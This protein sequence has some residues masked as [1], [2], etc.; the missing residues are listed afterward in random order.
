VTNRD[1]FRVYP[2]D[3]PY[4]IVALALFL[5]A[6]TIY[7]F[8]DTQCPPPP[9]NIPPTCK[10]I[11]VNPG[12]EGSLIGPGNILDAAEWARRMELFNTVQYWREKLKTAPAGTP[13][14]PPAPSPPAEPAK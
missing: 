2:G 4:L 1:L 12:E 7:A 9:P 10:V 3:A 5:A 14:A 13:Y 6:A 11:T 8:A